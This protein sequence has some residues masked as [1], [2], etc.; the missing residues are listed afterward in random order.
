MVW[1]TVQPVILGIVAP[2][3]L[4]YGLFQKLHNGLVVFGFYLN[5]QGVNRTIGAVRCPYLNSTVCGKVA[6][7]FAQVLTVI[8]VYNQHGVVH[9]LL[10]RVYKVGKHKVK[11]ILQAP[12]TAEEGELP[13]V[14]LKANQG[15]PRPI[16]RT[17]LLGFGINHGNIG[18][19]GCIVVNLKRAIF[20]DKTL[21]AA[22]VENLHLFNNALVAF[23]VIFVN[24]EKVHG[25]IKIGVCGIA[26]ERQHLVRREH[27]KGKRA[28]IRIVREHPRLAAC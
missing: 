19:G 26:P 18:A 23:F 9:I 13:V 16:Q 11:G 1:R 15:D 28:L 6:P 2:G 25:T 5:F 24:G 3:V 4:D 20:P 17:G 27:C 10:H 8:V 12:H 14:G 7:K 21:N 22:C